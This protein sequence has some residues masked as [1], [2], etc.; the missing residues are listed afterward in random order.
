MGLII[1]RPIPPDYFPAYTHPTV[2]PTTKTPYFPK[3]IPSIAPTISSDKPS[4][5]PTIYPTVFPTSVPSG[6]PTIEPIPQNLVPSIPTPLISNSASP[7]RLKPKLINKAKAKK[8]KPAVPTICE[9]DESPSCKPTQKQNI[10]SV[11][12]KKKTR[13]QKNRC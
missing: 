5:G 13:T 8:K 6:K 12:K 4:T 11:K 2:F 3:G 1:E 10:P 9:S 7:S